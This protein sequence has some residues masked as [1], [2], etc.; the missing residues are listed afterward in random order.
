M[1]IQATASAAAAEAFYKVRVNKQKAIS[2]GREYRK[3]E[4]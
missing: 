3:S 1:H 2:S 4:N